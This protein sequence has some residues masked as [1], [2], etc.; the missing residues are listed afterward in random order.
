MRTHSEE[1]IEASFDAIPPTV[2]GYF[3]PFSFVAGAICSLLMTAG[4][5]LLT[6]T[7]RLW[8]KPLR[9]LETLLVLAFFFW[10]T[11]EMFRASRDVACTG[12]RTP[13]ARVN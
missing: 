1:K 2:L 11:R 6:I 9:G 10:S 5:I 3:Y 4:I 7:H 8:A 13:N 12:D